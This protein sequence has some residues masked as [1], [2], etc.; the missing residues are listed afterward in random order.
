[1]EKLN[2][3]K[4]AKILKEKDIFI[5]SPLDFQR[6]FGVSYYAAKNFINRHTSSGLFTK[7]KNKLYVLTDARPPKFVLANKIYEPSY[8]SFETALSYYHIIPETIYTIFSAT[9]K[10]TREF[11]AL[12]VLYVYHR[13]KKKLF[14]AYT[15]DKIN[16]TN[17]LIAEPEKALVDFLYF[18]DLKKKNLIER[19]DL[20][21]FK[22][23]DIMKIATYFGRDSLVKL[24]NKLYGK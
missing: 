7:I 10:A 14:F 19:I 6:M 9:T 4:V 22:K 21:K 5:F 16:G 24:V 18:V 8:I 23:K 17:F 15:S 12:D 1:M 13:I 20:T 3:L 11:E 2:S